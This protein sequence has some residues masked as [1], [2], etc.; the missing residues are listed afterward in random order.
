MK[1]KI[2][3][4][5]CLHCGK[6]FTPTN[7]K[8]VYCSTAHR[9]A[10]GRKRNSVGGW[11]DAIK[12]LK[13]FSG[14]IAVPPDVLLQWLKANYPVGKKQALKSPENKPKDTQPLKKALAIPKEILEEVSPFHTVKE[15][16]NHR[17]DKV[18][19]SGRY[20]RRKD[21]LGF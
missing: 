1:K 2:E 4:I 14:S 18:Q 9:V 21:K 6:K 19:S 7:K 11:V 3:K 12:E 5:A 20:D 16:L 8:Q 13:A 10:G 15:I 17:A